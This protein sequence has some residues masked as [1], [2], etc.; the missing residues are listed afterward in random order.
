MKNGKTNSKNLY[1]LFSNVEKDFLCDYIQQTAKILSKNFFVI[2]AYYTRPYSIGYL[3]RNKETLIEILGNWK[4][5]I[6]SRNLGIYDCEFISL[7][8]FQR[9]QFIYEINKRLTR[10]EL[11]TILFL[12]KLFLKEKSSLI[13]WIFHQS[14]EFFVKKMKEK[15]SLY[16]YVD[17]VGGLTRLEKI[18]LR[19]VD[20][21]FANSEILASIKRQMRNDV[22]VVPCGCA[23][24]TFSTSI[25][26]EKPAHLKKI[27]KP[28]VGFFGHF[29]YRINYAL[30]KYLLS[31]NKKY[32]FVFIGKII[33]R[34]HFGDKR[35]YLAINNYITQLKKYNNF[36]LLPVVEKERLKNYL[37]YFDVALIPYN[38][39]EK[40]VYYSNPMK[41]YEYLTMGIPVVSAPIPALLK[42]RLR[43]IKFANSFE[44]FNQAMRFFVN[45]PELKNQYKEQMRQVAEENS[46]EKKVGKILRI[47]G[48]GAKR[49]VRVIT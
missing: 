41:F 17:Y 33:D 11:G 32:S 46:W 3:L 19:K 40:F 39:Y 14:A 38:L 25:Q 26:I 42:Y 12:R 5:I 30:V 44:E 45:H 9:F 10:F 49:R 8:P 4:K 35:S 13:L 34:T 31:R 24:E 27:K 15:I 2:V 28:I 23:I 7:I 20:F 21:I 18:L 36:I 16:D 43:I 6:T 37:Y 48:E 47:I 1:L 22:K 29:D